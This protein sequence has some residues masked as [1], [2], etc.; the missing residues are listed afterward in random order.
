MGNSF[1]LDQPVTIG[2]DFFKKPVMTSTGKAL[3]AQI[4]DTA[5]QEKHRALCVLHVRGKVVSLTIQTHTEL[6]L[7]LTHRNQN[8]QPYRSLTIG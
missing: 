3:K 7:S 8:H 6:L 2:V 4:W 5:G 1:F